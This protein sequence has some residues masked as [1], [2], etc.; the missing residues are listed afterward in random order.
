MNLSRK[1]SAIK[2]SVSLTLLFIATAADAAP[3]GTVTD[4][5][6][7]LLV[8]RANGS[9]KV[10]A[11]GSEIEPGDILASRK[12]TYATLTM[13]DSS[14]VTLGPDTDVKVERYVYYKHTPDNDGALLA[15][16][17]GS[18]RITAGVLG[19]RSGDT[20]TLTTPTATVDIRGASLIAEYVGP[21]RAKVASRNTLPRDSRLS[22]MV[23]VSYAPAADPGYVSTVSRSS[24]LRL[25]QISPPPKPTGGVP[26][27][28]YVQVLDGAIHLSNSGGTTSFSAGQFGYTANVN[29]PP[30]VLPANPGLQFTPPPSFSTTARS[31][32][33]AGSAA[34]SGTQKAKAVDCEVR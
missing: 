32:T 19:T 20:F 2:A 31:S 33:T 16:A 6:G 4:L 21:E 15:L 23:A 1:R 10:L 13:V 14:T 9:V 26:P 17:N 24:A 11:P 22:N 28:L 5:D 7:T 25:A 18:V 8:S 3:I 29:R 34:A 27:G 12:K 30:I